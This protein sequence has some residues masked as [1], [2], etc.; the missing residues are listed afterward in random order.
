MRTGS[1]LT[2]LALELEVKPYTR[3]SLLYD[4]SEADLLIEMGSPPRKTRA[5]QTA[6]AA[7]DLAPP[8]RPQ[9]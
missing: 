7:H 9:L 6:G 5:T 4:A 2:L 3:L 1:Q 8:G